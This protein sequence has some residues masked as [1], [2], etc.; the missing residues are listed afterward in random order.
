VVATLLAGLVAFL[1]VLASNHANEAGLNA[2]KFGIQAMG[3]LTRSLSRAEADYQ[4]FVLA[5]ELRTQEA[6]ARQ[7][8]MFL[9]EG[10]SLRHELAQRRLTS[11]RQ[12]TEHSDELRFSGIHG[13]G[14]DPAFPDRFFA[15]QT[16]DAVRL[17]AM[18][19]AWNEH[20][21]GHGAKTAVYIAVLTMFGVALYLFALLSVS[22]QLEV[23]R[24]FAVVAAALLV[25]GTSWT[26][27]VAAKDVDDV[28]PRAAA[29]FA[30]GHVALASAH[31]QDAYRK[32]LHHYGEAIEE[33]RTFARAYFEQATAI[34]LRASTSGDGAS[35]LDPREAL[36]TASD[37]R[38]LAAATHSLVMAHKHGLTSGP[39]L[40]RL[41]FYTFLLGR[42]GDTARQLE[43]SIDYTQQAVEADRIEPAWHYNLGLAL[44]AAGRAD[45]AQEQYTRAVCL[46]L[47]EPVRKGTEVEDPR[48]SG[49]VSTG[50]SRADDEVDLLEAEALSNL[51]LLARSKDE[52]LARDA[53]SMKDMVVGS[54]STRRVAGPGTAGALYP[55]ELA[56]MPG[57]IRFGPVHGYTTAR[58]TL[59][60]QVYYVEAGPT[61]TSHVIP[62]L[63]GAIDA[64][65]GSSVRMSYLTETTPARCLP[66]G[67]YRIELYADGELVGRGVDVATSDAVHQAAVAHDLGLRACVPYGWRHADEA[68]PGLLY[69]KESPD[70]A[71]GA[72]LFRFDAHP[73]RAATSR[74]FADA[75]VRLVSGGRP[76]PTAHR[77]H[78]GR[79]FGSLR[80]KVSRRYVIDDGRVAETRA[81]IDEDDAALVV[82][83]LGPEG[84]AQSDTAGVI[85]RSVATYDG[86]T[87]GR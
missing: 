10:P 76:V 86:P 17:A 35:V 56:V 31:D 4:L 59:S 84:Y 38:A 11:L 19:D 55:I 57:R 72:Y 14:R 53:Q 33:R 18:Q 67:R 62:E 83:L 2:D 80:Q 44:L 73:A 52:H 37:S 7:E 40:G 23:K 60:A 79:P 9:R 65:T 49:V 15:S 77:S 74:R 71:R 8:D 22:I 46:T 58:P 41:G 45:E 34:L 12:A 24:M 30:R 32:A 16:K 64:E 75:A 69:G 39:V 20:A 25:A 21:S 29:Q 26:V 36:E 28:E 81:G 82:V 5:E 27:V 63:S 68:M 43:R 3:Q 54:V 48:C 51:D 87:A 1:L 70:G 61:G 42:H 78:R 6:F 13:P 47:Y 85:M 66:D 50:R